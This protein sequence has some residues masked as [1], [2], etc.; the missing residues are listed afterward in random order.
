MAMVCSGLGLDQ[1]TVNFI[2]R[3]PAGNDFDLNIW[4]AEISV[5]PSKQLR[6]TKSCA[7]TDTKGASAYL[8]VPQGLG[9]GLHTRNIC[10]RIYKL[11]FQ[12]LAY[13]R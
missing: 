9:A 4:F 5:A 13:A 8:V 11:G 12:T 3:Y 10:E 2:E 6:T 1:T 7:Q